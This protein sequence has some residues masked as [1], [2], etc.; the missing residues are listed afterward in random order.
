MHTTA[1]F[2]SRFEI[3]LTFYFEFSPLDDIMTQKRFNLE[4]LGNTQLVLSVIQ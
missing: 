3:V 4:E 2:V 1:I